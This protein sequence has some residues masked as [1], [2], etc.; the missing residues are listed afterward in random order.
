MGEKGWRLAGGVGQQG[1][2]NGWCVQRVLD[3]P[4]G[5]LLAGER[6]FLAVGPREAVPGV[7]LDGAGGMVAGGGGEGGGGAE[8]EEGGGGPSCQL[9]GLLASKAP[10]DDDDGAVQGAGMVPRGRRRF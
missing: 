5:A 8:G 6:D 3:E 4:L 9:T 1:W 2:E 10:I 7:R